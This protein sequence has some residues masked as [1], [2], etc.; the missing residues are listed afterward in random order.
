MLT[1]FDS[2]LNLHTTKILYKSR[3]V[4]NFALR[5]IITSPQ[6]LS[7]KYLLASR[8]VR[9]LV[10]SRSANTAS[11]LGLRLVRVSI[12]VMD[13]VRI[14][15][16]ANKRVKLINYSLITVSPVATST[17]PHIHI[18]PVPRG[19]ADFKTSFPGVKGRWK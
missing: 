19:S 18:L 3:L 16:R 5:K 6:L 14:S 1:N 12:R 15:N 17:D 2:Y 10:K 7:A 11:V 4:R 9:A 8:R 13:R